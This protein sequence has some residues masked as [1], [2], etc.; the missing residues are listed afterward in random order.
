MT[1]DLFGKSYPV[2]LPTRHAE[3]HELCMAYS[4]NNVR[5]SAAILG[6]CVPELWTEGRALTFGYKSCG[7]DAGEYGARCWDILRAAGVD[8]ATFIAA[9]SPIFVELARLTLPTVSEVA[10]RVGFSEASAGA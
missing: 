1:I 9:A 2:T 8:E 5:G 3:R 4:A 6:L 10:K 7:Y